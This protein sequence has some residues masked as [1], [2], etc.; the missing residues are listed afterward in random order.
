MSLRTMQLGFPQ[1]STM[2]AWR[3]EAGTNIARH[4]GLEKTR[5]FMAH[6]PGS[7]T[8]Q[9]WYES[10]LFDLDVFGIAAREQQ[11]TD[12]F[13]DATSAAMQRADIV[14]QAM[15]RKAIVEAWVEEQP[16]IKTF[17]ASGNSHQLRLEKKRLRRRA[18]KALAEQ[19][20]QEAVAHYTVDDIA[21]RHKELS[22]PSK[23]FEIIS[24][25]ARKVEAQQDHHSS[26]S[27]TEDDNAD[28]EVY[29][30]S[31]TDLEDDAEVEEAIGREV[32]QDIHLRVVNQE[33]NG[34]EDDAIDE[35]FSLEMIDLIRSFVE[36]MLED[37]L[38]P[39]Q[40]RPCPKCRIERYI[41]Q[42]EKVLSNG[43]LYKRSKTNCSLGEDVR[44]SIIAA[45][46]FRF[47]VPQCVQHMATQDERRTRKRL[48]L[49][50]P[51]WL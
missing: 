8:F 5:K 39:G 35:G 9:R 48:A 32:G 38:L 50:M 34:I 21:R 40:P 45:T 31:Y 3:R 51:I 15:Q 30:N 36:F 44:Q 12:T 14:N 29:L 13:S 6:R 42:K 10:E 18:T 33:D 4:S 24:D 26:D 49:E 43:K 28:D 17:A 19:A 47:Q 37:R 25:R 46:T 1:G 7:A 23:I 16:S 11:N 27:D 22:N 41:T 2:Y 20:R